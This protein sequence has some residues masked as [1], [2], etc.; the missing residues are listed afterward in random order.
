MPSGFVFEKNNNI[1]EGKTIGS[2]VNTIGVVDYD[3][4]NSFEYELVSGEGDEQNEFFNLSEDG[5]L[6]TAQTIDFEQNAELSIRVEVTDDHN[7]SFSKSFSIKV[8]NVFEDADNDGIEDHED[9]SIDTD[10]DGT[11]DSE[12]PDIDGDGMSNSE[13]VANGSDPRDV[14]SIN[15]APTVI[16]SIEG[17]SFKENE[18]AGILV[19]QLIA[20]DVDA[21]AIH[22]FF[23]SAG[24]EIHITHSLPLASR[25]NYVLLILFIS[26][27]T[28]LISASGPSP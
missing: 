27:I 17:L 1:T 4:G 16:S 21:G 19:G 3:I 9:P 7:Q 22:E 12:D 11:E 28:P 13:E 18:P 2:V 24:E 14:N 10:Q 26:M 15:H 6:I 20:S 25:V 5:E 23:L 8:V